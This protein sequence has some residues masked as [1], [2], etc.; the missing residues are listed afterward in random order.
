MDAGQ[1]LSGHAFDEHGN[2]SLRLS[3]RTRGER[4]SA[5]ARTK[6]SLGST[7]SHPTKSAF[8]RRDAR[9]GPRHAGARALPGSGKKRGLRRRHDEGFP[10]RNGRRQL[11]AGNGLAAG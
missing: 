2:P 5:G 7:E 4:G 11:A 1:N 3:P 8:L 10:D 6:P 9:R